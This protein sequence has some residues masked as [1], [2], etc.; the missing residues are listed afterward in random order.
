MI[1]AKPITFKLVLSDPKS[2]NPDAPTTPELTR[3]T[4]CTVLY[5]FNNPYAVRR[6]RILKYIMSKWEPTWC[7]KF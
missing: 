1:D 2:V 3:R 7:S 6:T 5:R 4:T